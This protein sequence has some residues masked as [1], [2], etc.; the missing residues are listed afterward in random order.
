MKSLL[1]SPC[2]SSITVTLVL[3]IG[4]AETGTETGI[5]QQRYTCAAMLAT[6]GCAC[7]ASEATREPTCA[8]GSR[9]G[10]A[11][12]LLDPA[13]DGSTLATRV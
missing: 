5:V 2:V 13:A 1:S 7:E 6:P 10:E 11:L 4:K 9:E 8:Q 12:G 3:V